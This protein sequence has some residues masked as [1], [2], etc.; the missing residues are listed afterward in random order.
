MADHLAVS[1]SLF[2]FIRFVIHIDEWLPVTC[3]CLGEGDQLI[4]D[5]VIPDLFLWF[6][7]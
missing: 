5:H 3:V 2:V 1:S 7:P 6:V 4:T